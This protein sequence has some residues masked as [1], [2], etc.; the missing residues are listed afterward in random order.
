MIRCLA[1]D[2]ETPALDILED[3]IKQVPFLQ[4]VGKCK[5]AYA[6]ME[7]MQQEPVDLLFLDIEMPGIS[8]LSFLKSLS[9][10]PMVIFITAYRN[11]A[12]EGFDLDV[13]DYLVKPVS[14]E[15][16]LKAVNKALEYQR[17]KQKEDSPN[18]NY[19][20]YL[21]IHTE[22]QLTKVFIHEIAY[23]EG[24]R[25]YIRIHLTGSAKPLLSKLSLKA[26]EEKLPP[27]KCARVHKS[28]IV[29]LD[30]IS[31]IRNDIIRIGNRDIPLS[32]SCRE[33]F[34]KKINAAS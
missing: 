11:Y 27:G 26:I 34:L 14:F 33:D 6:A 2:D 13:L 15:R 3:N 22:Y 17:F 28:F 21:F 16:F 8:G 1:I 5:N 23:I 4:L 20:D 24:L 31:S 10:R 32:R 25:N 7:T 9:N 19:P 18:N 30:K 12:V 29:L